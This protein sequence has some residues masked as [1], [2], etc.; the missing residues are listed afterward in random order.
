MYSEY[1]DRAAFFVVYIQEAHPT[2]LW[3]LPVNVREEVLFAS[4]KTSD[5]RAGVAAA[6]VRD[7]GIKLPALLDQI[8]DSTEKAYTAWPDRLYV[9][10]RE[11][12]VAY[13]SRPG[14]FGFKP[15]EMEQA[16]K[17]LL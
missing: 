6:C 8:D 15:A 4:P 5:E 9:I 12:R 14:P 3:Q 10:D 13:K 7:L 16:L 11:G 2:D 17:A 1:G